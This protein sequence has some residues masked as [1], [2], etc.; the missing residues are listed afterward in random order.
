MKDNEKGLREGHPKKASLGSTRSLLGQM[1]GW[2]NM[3]WPMFYATDINTDDC[4]WLTSVLLWVVENV[5]EADF[6]GCWL[7]KGS[8]RSGFRTPSNVTSLWYYPLSRAHDTLHWLVCGPVSSGAIITASLAPWPGAEFPITPA[9]LTTTASHDTDTAFTLDFLHD[10]RLWMYFIC[11][12][13]A[14]ILLVYT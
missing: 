1:E 5:I 3:Q 11:D 12:A 9:T 14:Y 8:C 4:F 2:L 6:P 7:S 13:F 10:H